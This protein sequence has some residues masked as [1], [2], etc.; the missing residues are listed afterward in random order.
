MLGTKKNV[1]FH[2]DLFQANVGYEMKFS[3]LGMVQKHFPVSPIATFPSNVRWQWTFLNL[4]IADKLSSIESQRS[5]TR[6]GVDISLFILLWSWQNTD[7]LSPHISCKDRVSGQR[8]VK[9]HFDCKSFLFQL[10]IK[11]LEYMS[12]LWREMFIWMARVVYIFVTT[13]IHTWQ[14]SKR[15]TPDAS[16]DD[17]QHNGLFSV[18]LDLSKLLQ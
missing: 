10:V 7:R 6:N 9:P 3:F 5:R 4:W 15:T 8:N 18:S 13:N 14:S 12:L 11:A 1:K 17:P 2:E 16:K